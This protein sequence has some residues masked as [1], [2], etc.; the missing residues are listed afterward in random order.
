[1]PAMAPPD[2]PSSESSSGVAVAEGTVNV[3]V[4]RLVGSST[5]SHRSSTLLLT[6]HESVALMPP[7]AQY[8]H[9]PKVLSAK[10]Q[11]SGSLSMPLIHREGV[12]ASSGKPQVVKSARIRSIRLSPGWGH[13]FVSA[14][15]SASL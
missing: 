1:M 13:R 5:S 11:F 14:E 2:R 15:T 3:M 12:R 7:A 6:Q 10:P 8:V 4:G 9:K